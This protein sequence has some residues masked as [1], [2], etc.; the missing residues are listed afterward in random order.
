MTLQAGQPGPSTPDRRLVLLRHAKAEHGGAH[1]DHNRALALEG[2]RQAGQV[3]AALRDA[4]LVPD[5]VLCSSSVR[6]RQTW[7]LVR[8]GLGAEV[9]DVQVL[10]ALYEAGARD[11]LEL[12]RGAGDAVRTLLVVGHEP[13]M[14]QA[15]A[16][17]AGPGSDEAA[18]MRVR[19]GVPTGSWTLL[20]AARW[21]VL[22][23]DG[24]RLVRLVTPG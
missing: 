9:G 10:D 22:E 18:Q 15:A 24:A 8:A 5:L 1:D 16:M 12:V 19:T 11:V 4:G 7:D 23:P 21:D 3:G 2:R 20:E 13:T 6:T 17:L 14:S